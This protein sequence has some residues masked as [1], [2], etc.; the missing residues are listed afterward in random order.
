MKHMACALLMA[1]ATAAGGEPST[2]TAPEHRQFDFWI[3]EWVVY[4]PKGDRVGE[5]RITRS[6]DGCALIENWTGQGGFS[7]MSSNR[8]EPGRQRWRQRWLDNQGG[9][10]DL[11]GGLVGS[12]MVLSGEDDEPASEG[13][14][15]GVRALQ[16]ITWTPHA[17]G[18]VRQL[19]ESSID[20]GRSWSAA[21]DG[22]Y[23]R[24][25]RP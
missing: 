22:R 11:S 15:K 14:S 24:T 3:G 1:T 2:C 7:G 16:R 23:V 9:A 21:F 5:N 6:P 10:L 12:A 8:Y 25:Q 20:A 17:D 13:P 18:S 19:W 4:G